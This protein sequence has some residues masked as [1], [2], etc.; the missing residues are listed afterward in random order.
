MFNRKMDLSP[1]KMMRANTICGRLYIVLY[2]LFLLIE[3]NALFSGTFNAFTVIRCVLYI[4]VGISNIFFIRREGEKRTTMIV[5]SG[6]FALLYVI[7]LMTHDP[8]NMIA[9]LPVIIGLTVYLNVRL[10]MFGTGISSFFALVKSIY[11]YGT[12]DM[13]QFKICMVILLCFIIAAYICVRNIGLLIDFSMEDQDVINQK[14]EQH[15]EVATMVSQIVSDINVTFAETL[16][17]MHD[18]SESVDLTTESV[19]SI[20]DSS[21]HT[22]STAMQ[23]AEMTGEIQRKL[24]TTDSKAQDALKTTDN[25]LGMINDGI[26]SAADL[27][28]Q[29]EMVDENTTKISGI[30]DQL[31]KNVDQVS[32]ITSSILNIS[33]QTNLLALNASIEAARAGEAG[34]GFAV[35]ADEIRKLAEETRSSTEKITLIMGEL[36]A[37]TSDTREEI[38]KSVESI[39]A[40]HEKVETVTASFEQAG[41][42]V[43]E[44]SNDVKDMSSSVGDVMKANLQIVDSIQNLSGTSEEVA[45]ETANSRERMERVASGIKTF[46]DSITET[47]ERLLRLEEVATME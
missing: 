25:L 34:R 45:A 36:N 2:V 26:Q 4:V 6:S 33:S 24:E 1:D 20:A 39:R 40:Q 44:L 18:I 17:N 29:S 15:K 7:M 19:A 21:E 8:I 10:L 23:Q 27:K 47:S 28:K 9:V 22:A 43:Q 46:A 41:V 11:I 30:V 13:V 14:M 35:V 5:I 42:R 3:S 12:G 32:D 38:T 16:D 37:V 31:V